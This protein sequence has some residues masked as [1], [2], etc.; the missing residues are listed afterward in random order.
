MVHWGSVMN[1]GGLMMHS[2]VDWLVLGEHNIV[3]NN[4]GVV[5][6]SCVVDWSSSVVHWG[7]MVHWGG[8]LSNRCLVMDGSNVTRSL[9]MHSLVDGL[10]EHGSGSVVNGSCCVVHWGSVM[11]GGRVMSNWCLMVHWSL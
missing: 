7:S 10:V 3:I 8:V 4:R 2:L 1:W 5:H 6:R 9:V 11:H